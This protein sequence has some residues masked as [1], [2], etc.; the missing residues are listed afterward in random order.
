M[1]KIVEN[2]VLQESVGSGQYGK[3]YKAK[4]TKT[5]EVVAVKV[6]KLSKFSE[7]P[8]LEEFTLN[9][10]KTL[11]KVENPNVVRFI[12]MLRTSNNM[13]LIYE[14]CNGGT[15]EQ[16]LMEKK[17]LSEKEALHLFQ[18]MLNAFLP[19]HKSN[20]LHRDLKPSN[21]LLHNGVLKI[22]DFGFCKSLKGPLELAQTIVG[23]PIY[24][25]PEIL[26]GNSYSSKADLWSLGVVFFELLF[27]CCPFEEKSIPRLL[28]QIETRGL[29][30]PKNKNPISPKVEETLKMMLNPDPNRRADWPYL[31]SQYLPQE[32][33]SQQPFGVQQQSGQPSG[34]VNAA[35]PLS[36]VTNTAVNNHNSI[37]APTGALPTNMGYGNNVAT[38]GQKNGVQNQVGHLN[39]HATGNIPPHINLNHG[40]TTPN[41]T[42]GPHINLYSNTVTAYTTTH[43]R[44]NSQLP[45][46]NFKENVV[47][48]DIQKGGVLNPNNNL[49][50]N[51]NALGQRKVANFANRQESPTDESKTRNRKP[52]PSNIGGGA[53]MSRGVP[54]GTTNLKLLLRERNKLL[55]MAYTLNNSIDL[56]LSEISA[57]VSFLL[58]KQLTIASLNFRR[59]ITNNTIVNTIKELENWES[60]KGTGEFYRFL[61]LIDK[62]QEEISR[63]MHEYRDELMIWVAS[64]QGDENPE[65]AKQLAVEINDNERVD[66]RFF[67]SQ[68]A[69]YIEEVQQAA[70]QYA[71][72]KSM[73]NGNLDETT[74]SKKPAIDQEKKLLLHAIEISD[75]LLLDECF[76]S[77]MDVNTKYNE[78][79]YFAAL[80]NST[81]DQ[82][83]TLIV[84]KADFIKGK[85]W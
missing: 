51:N 25:A 78:Q 3:V 79:K 12:E 20:I 18:Q 16:L 26:K 77:L 46:G 2:Y 69:T 39:H 68:L 9:E 13:Y 21:I 8:K 29:V 56:N 41:G 42:G 35:A 73:N 54:S 65:L 57:I 75:T 84:Q 47:T 36:N 85:N 10:I 28:N 59:A 83:R 58:M 30:I 76:D 6:I 66:M 1:S 40:S 44:Q 38:P 7:V 24:M 74:V 61:E 55:F 48:P 45:H 49:N 37:G 5:D 70:R 27:G 31:F 71:L 64:P 53:Q 52:M 15:L 33:I 32:G 14:F 80:R 34:Q 17:F 60:F 23:S 22:A 82:L 11:S 72:N 4:N 43:A 67:R 81:I 19:L 62:E 50:N 63:V